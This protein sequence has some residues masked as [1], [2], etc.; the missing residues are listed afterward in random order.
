MNFD[1]MAR[2]QFRLDTNCSPECEYKYRIMINEAEIH[3]GARLFDGMSKDF[4]AIIYKGDAYI[5]A[6]KEL[7]PWVREKYMTFKCEWF[8]KF[9]NLRTLDKKLE[10]YGL[11]I[12]DTHIYFL[13]DY[14]WEDIELECP[15]ETRWFDVDNLGELSASGKFPHAFPGAKLQPDVIG[16]AAYDNGIPIAAAGASADGKYMWQIGIDVDRD[17]EHHGLALYLVTAL[18][19]KIIE[20]G[21]L[22][23][24]GTSESH[25]I[26]QD[27]A[28]VSGFMPAWAEIFVKKI[29]KTVD[30]EES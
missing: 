5:M 15:Y 28:I 12:H 14:N 26:S 7:L 9:E 25:S 18:K 1:D 13:P 2:A 19:E 21:F 17:Y 16:I 8:C 30:K 4:R 10:E 6:S 22:P 23:Y 3:E 29:E 11:C 20:K 24:Y 27:V